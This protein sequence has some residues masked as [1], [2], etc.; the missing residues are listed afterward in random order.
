M[1]ASRSR[2]GSRS[3]PTRPSAARSSA[4]PARTARARRRAGSSTSWP[5]AGAD[6]SA[7]VGRA[8]AVVDHGR[9]AGHGSV[10]ERRRLRRRGRR[11]RRQ[12]RCLPSRAGD[13]DQRRVGPSGRLRRTGRRSRRPS[14]RGC[15]GRRAEPRSSPTSATPA[16]K[17]SST[18]LPTG[19]ARSSPTRSSTRRHNGWAATPARSPS[20]IRPRTARPRP[21]SAG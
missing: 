14:S 3:S 6:P 4:W 2:R 12:L 5:A 18:G 1:P 8:A 11:V 20:G 13:P 17:R 16:S 9:P 21:C 7:F 15:A 19:P 10:G